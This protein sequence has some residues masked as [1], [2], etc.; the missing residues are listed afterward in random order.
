VFAWYSSSPSL[1]VYVQH[2]NSAGAEVFPHN[3]V[4][5]STNASQIRVSPSASYDATTQEIF[6]SYEEEDSLQSM[7]GVYAQKFDA[8]GN[9]QW[10][11]TGLAIVPLQGNDA[12]IFERTVQIGDGVFVFWVD[13]QVN[14]NGTLQGVKLNNNGS[15]ACM[16][17]A[18]SSVVAEKSRPWTAQAANS[19]T[20]VAFQDYRDGNSNLYIQNVNPDCTLGIE[21]RATQ[22]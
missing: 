9:R 7:S 4:V 5:A 17:F 11:D 19:N 15:T 3:G 2:I 16:Q 20:V 10:G 18:V 8:S 21:M 1:Q 12:E 6:V 14:L 22:R 13:Q